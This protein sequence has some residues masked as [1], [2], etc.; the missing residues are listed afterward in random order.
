MRKKKTYNLNKIL[1]NAIRRVWEYSPMRN[2]AKNVCKRYEPRYK[3]D[4]TRHKVDKFIGYE[5]TKCHKI[6][7]KIE[8]HHLVPVSD[9]TEEFNWN[10]HINRM[11]HGVMVGLCRDC[12]L[13]MH[14]ERKAKPKRR[15]K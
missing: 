9:K 14:P 11:F 7:E 10:T 6:V 5:C 3:K 8:I 12:H 15:K 13:D 4:G 1:K 2:D